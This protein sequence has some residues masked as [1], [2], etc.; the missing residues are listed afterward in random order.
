MWAIG[1]PKELTPSLANASSTSKGEPDRSYLLLLA[2]PLT[3]GSGFF[4]SLRRLDAP[5]ALTAPQ[6]E[7]R[8]P[9]RDHVKHRRKHQTECG[10]PDHTGEYR[11]AERL[12]QF[13]AGA[14]RPDQRRDAEDEGERSHQDRAEPQPRRLDRSLPAGTALVFELAGEFDDQDGVLGRQANQHH[15]AD[16][17]EGVFVLA[18]QG[19][20]GDG[21]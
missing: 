19:D 13:G 14:D 8:N 9:P 1:P 20:A 2:N 11:G 5:L 17:G 10:H 15:E 6:P 4:I 21:G 7:L 3:A 12:A 18:A 16:L